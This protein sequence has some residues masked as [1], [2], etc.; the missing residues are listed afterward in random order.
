MDLLID[1]HSRTP[2]YWQLAN[3]LKAKIINGEIPDGAILP[4]ERTMASMANV[5]RNTVIKAYS[6][7]K[8]QGYVDSHQGAGYYVNYKTCC[9]DEPDMRMKV[10]WSHIIKDRYQDMEHTFDDIYQKFASTDTISL[11]TGMAP[12]VYYEQNIVSRLTEV[13]SEAG[14]RPSLL[15][16]Y[17]GDINL[18]KEIVGFLRKKGIK[19][20]TN[21]IQIVTETNQALDYIVSALLNPGDRIILEEPVSPDVYRVLELA[22]CVPVTVPVDEHGM[23]CDHL[24]ALIEKHKPKLLYVNSSFHD[25]AGCIM[26]IERRKKI[27]ELSNHYRLPVVEDDA[28]SELSFNGEILPPIKAMDKSEN[29]IYIYSFSLTF[30]P[31]ITMAFVLAPPKL[32]KV[33]AHLISIKMI[34]LDWLTQKLLACYMKDGQYEEKIHQIVQLNKVKCDIMCGYLDTL[35]DLGVKY[36]KPEGGVYIWC[37]LPDRMNCKKVMTEALKNGV[38][39]IPGTVFFPEKN[40]G[41][42]YIRLNFSYESKS[43]IHQGMSILVEIIRKLAH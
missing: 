36:S 31:G 22:G 37:R 3:I 5:H 8:D 15:S 20:E 13:L 39:I 29:V 35:S 19:A 21:E 40:G 32:S 43:R 42:N 1:K 4:S 24:E 17:Q 16:P 18:R 11:A 9:D 2:F 38:S 28:T 34:S 23:M 33:L 12:A 27:I 7:L 14:R 26:S 25:P 41:Q 6:L 10:N 30:I